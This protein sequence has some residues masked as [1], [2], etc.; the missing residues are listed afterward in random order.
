MQRAFFGKRLFILYGLKAIL[1]R[2]ELEGLLRSI[3]YEKLEVLLLDALQRGPAAKGETLTII[4][5][6]L[7]ILR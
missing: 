2:D 5:E 4:D 7:C 3:H 1:S 6:D